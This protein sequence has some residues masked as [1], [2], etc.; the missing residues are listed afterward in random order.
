MG[1]CG[2]M[3]N[4]ETKWLDAR[5]NAA[6]GNKFLASHLAGLHEICD[7]AIWLVS[8]GLPE[9]LEQVREGLRGKS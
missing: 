2:D 8:S 3:D 7:V 4:R 6:G 1:E 9:A 5:D